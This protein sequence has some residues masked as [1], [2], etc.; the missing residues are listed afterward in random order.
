[1]KEVT[2]RKARRQQQDSRRQKI[3]ETAAKERDR[4]TTK[5]QRGFKC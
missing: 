5:K 1:M 4:Q 2:N 3:C